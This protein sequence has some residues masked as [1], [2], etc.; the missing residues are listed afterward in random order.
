MFH[1]YREHLD[2]TMLGFLEVDAA[3][4]INLSKRGPRLLDYVGPGGAPSIIEGAKTVLFVGKWMQGAEVGIEGDRLRLVK[5]GKPKLVDHVDEITFNGDVGLARGKQIFYVTDL[6]LLE[7]TGQGLTLRAVMPGIDIQ[8]D[9][10]A[11][12]GARIHVPDDPAPEV[13]PGAVVTGEGF[14]LEWQE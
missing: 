10:L 5:P 11:N 8:R 4:N 7:L 2:A 13:V 3:G 9:L 14:D 1:H 6:A 12:S